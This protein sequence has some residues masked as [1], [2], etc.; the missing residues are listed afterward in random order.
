MNNAVKINRAAVRAAD[1]RRNTQ[2]VGTNVRTL[3]LYVVM[4]DDAKAL[5]PEWLEQFVAHQIQEATR[6]AAAKLVEEVFG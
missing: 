6:N 5:G 3:R 4:P 1:R 2:R